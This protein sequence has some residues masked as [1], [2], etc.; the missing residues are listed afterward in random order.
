M[1]TAIEKI[2]KKNYKLILFKKINFILVEWIN[3]N[4]GF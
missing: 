3:I 1:K 2:R 4:L